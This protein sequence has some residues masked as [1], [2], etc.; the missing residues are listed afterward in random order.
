MWLK[1]LKALEKC[2]LMC[3]YLHSCVLPFTTCRNAILCTSDIWILW[4]TCDTKSVLFLRDNVHRVISQAR[5]GDWWK[6]LSD[7]WFSLC[8]SPR[9]RPFPLLSGPEWS[10]IWWESFE[11]QE[12]RQKLNCFELKTPGDPPKKEISSV[13]WPTSA[14]QLHAFSVKVSKISDWNRLYMNRVEHQFLL[15][16]CSWHCRSRTLLVFLHNK[17]SHG[18]L[19]FIPNHVFLWHA[20][21]ENKHN[22]E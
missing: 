3:R 21:S 5:S 15:R 13:S 17:L 10:Q 18:L 22:S 7:F 20:L 16:L 1:Y 2:L 11:P 9:S 6:G 14:T 19:S 4:N 12:V 8:S